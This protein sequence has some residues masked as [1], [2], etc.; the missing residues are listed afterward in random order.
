[1]L[2][3]LWSRPCIALMARSVHS[4]TETLATDDDMAVSTTE[5]AEED[6]TAAIAA[7]PSSST[8]EFTGA[9]TAVTAKTL[10]TS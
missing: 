7:G 1:M 3:E 10:T 6:D 2:L 9:T 5:A 4:P 8:E